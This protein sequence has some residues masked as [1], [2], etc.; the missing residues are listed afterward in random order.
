MVLQG[1]EVTQAVVQEREEAWKV[2][3]GMESGG[4]L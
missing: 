4:Q 3:I 1:Q 2:V